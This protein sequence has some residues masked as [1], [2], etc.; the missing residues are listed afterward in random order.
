M[1]ADRVVAVSAWLIL[2]SGLGSVVGPLIGSY[3]MARFSIDAVFYFMAATA[4]LLAIFAAALGFTVP[5]PPHHARTFNI[6]APQA[7]PLAH[8]FLG[9]V[10]GS[11]S[12]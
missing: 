5:P 10:D 12:S 6:L 7:A 9:P 8:D 3:V 2:V 4:G 11:S 1:P